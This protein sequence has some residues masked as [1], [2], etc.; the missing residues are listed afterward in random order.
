MYIGPGFWVLVRG[1]SVKKKCEGFVTM[2]P[3][4]TTLQKQMLQASDPV[5]A[6]QLAGSLD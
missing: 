1:Q 6:G 3:S 4:L 2:T 5:L